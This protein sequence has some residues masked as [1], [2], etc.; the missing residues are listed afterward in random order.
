MTANTQSPLASDHPLALPDTE[1]S[2]REVFGIDIDMKAPAFSLGSEH[3]PEI[4]P[5][6]RFDRDTTLAILAG[7]AFNR[8]VMVQGFHGTGKST[9]IVQ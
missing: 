4:D 9:H 2:V 7:F 3:V 5:A 8:R 6:Y 1:V